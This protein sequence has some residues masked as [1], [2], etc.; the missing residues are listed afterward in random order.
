MLKNLTQT[1]IAISLALIATASAAHAGSTINYA[2]TAVRVVTAD[3]API[4]GAD[5]NLYIARD[6]WKLR[7]GGA[8]PEL[9]WGSEQVKN[10]TAKTDANGETTFESVAK[11]SSSPS[12]KGALLSISVRS[13]WT[14]TCSNGSQ[15]RGPFASS[16]EGATGCH[17]SAETENEVAGAPRSLTC[18][19]SATAAD[20]AREKKEAK[21]LCNR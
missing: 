17:F 15:L 7:T 13:L 4:Q 3:G 2:G 20:I 19:V 8:F 10:E 18:T 14:V 11:K 16:A 21:A 6:E 9:G 1:T 12:V 5:V